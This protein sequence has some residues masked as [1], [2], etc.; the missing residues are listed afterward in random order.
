MRLPKRW[1]SF[2]TIFSL[3]ASLSLSAGASI[4]ECNEPQNTRELIAC[5]VAAKS[6]SQRIVEPANEDCPPRNQSNPPVAVYRSSASAPTSFGHS[7]SGGAVAPLD[8]LFFENGADCGAFI[9][10]SGALGPHGEVIAEYIQGSDVR[11]LYYNDNIP[12]MSYGAEVCS[13]WTGM[14]E[15]ER[16]HFWVWTFAAIAWDE[17]TCIDTARNEAG[18]NEPAVGLFQL[19]ESQEGRNWRGS[20]CATLTVASPVEQNIK[21]GL[22]IM[23]EQ[24]KGPQGMYRTS[25]AVFSSTGENSYWEKLRRRGGGTIGERIRTHPSCQN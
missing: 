25:G 2:L 24:L 17:S 23:T 12:E 10:S 6:T 14:S 13:N 9:D 1:P 15:D 21:C 19:N 3:G 4:E 22:D 5:L 11:D 18:T 8:P 20:N 16:T 7:S